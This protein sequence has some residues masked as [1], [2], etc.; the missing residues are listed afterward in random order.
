MKQLKLPKPEVDLKG[1][2]LSKL[3]Q[4]EYRHFWTLLIWPI[5]YLR[6]FIIEAIN[7][8]PAQCHLVYSPLDDLIP[9]CEFFLIPY[10]IWMVCLLGMHLFT[11]LYDRDV[12]RRYTLFLVISFTI[13]TTIYIVYP[14]YQ[15][16][17]PESFE[18]SNLFTWILGMVYQFD[19]STNVCPSEH[20]IGAM[21]VLAAAINCKY[22]RKPIRLTAVTVLMILVS[23]STVFLKQHSI[24]D[25]AAAMPV[26]LVAY[27]I[28][29][30]VFRKNRA[31]EENPL[32]GTV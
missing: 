2:R 20:V 29:F 31:S 19:T 7:A 13:S 25:V 32:L 11:L 18:R 22:F 14:T 4:K 10:G 27:L 23:L 30:P 1:F 9:L 21:A 28:C 26:C 17:R 8:N 5:Y 12:C 3:N 15:N 6:Y 16:L 24:V